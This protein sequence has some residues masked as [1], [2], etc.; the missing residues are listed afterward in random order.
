MPSHLTQVTLAV[1]AIALV[2]WPFL[3]SRRCASGRANFNPEK[4]IIQKA[5]NNIADSDVPGTEA[6][7]EECI[8]ACCGLIMEHL[9]SVS[10]ASVMDIHYL[11]FTPWRRKIIRAAFDDLEEHKL[12]QQVES[13]E[14]ENDY[15]V[16][17]RLVQSIAH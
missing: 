11:D 14:I 17:Y 13:L 4:E 15:N 8:S 5:D 3:R 12:I 10:S 6:H 1:F 7:F 16:K 9:Q 2:S